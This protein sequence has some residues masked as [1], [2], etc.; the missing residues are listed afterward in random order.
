MGREPNKTG[1][2]SYCNARQ[3]LTEESLMTL[4][5]QSGNNLGSASLESWLWFNRRVVIVD[6]STLSMPE[7]AENQKTYPQYGSQKKRLEIRS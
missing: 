2:S 1:S 7:T 5:T 4:L 3:R 6:G